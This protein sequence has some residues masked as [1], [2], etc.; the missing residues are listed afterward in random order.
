MDKCLKCQ[1]NISF[2]TGKGYTVKGELIC[3]DCWNKLPYKERIRALEKEDELKK[4]HKKEEKINKIKE[5]KKKGVWKCILNSTGGIF[6]FLI[7]FDLFI[8]II[9]NKESIL[10]EMINQGGI[11]GGILW[12]IL[13]IFISSLILS[14]CY[15]GL[16]FWW[17][18]LKDKYIKK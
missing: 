16:K 10:R 4:E 17:W 5:A 7:L 2:F 1:K 9:E 14:L 12:Y 13:T 11:F 6:T 3:A 18:K 15:N 8:S